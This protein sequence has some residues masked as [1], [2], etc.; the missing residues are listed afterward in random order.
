MHTDG[1]NY[2]AQQ[3]QHEMG[4]V[5]GTLVHTD[6][7]LVPIEQL[8][9][10]DMVLSKHESGKGEQA[11][12]RVINTFKSAEKLPIV[13]VEFQPA[14]KPCSKMHLFCTDNHPFWTLTQEDYES[15]WNWKPASDLEIQAAYVI[16][17]NENRLLIS[18]TTNYLFA[19][20]EMGI[21]YEIYG[22]SRGCVLDGYS[23]IIDFRNS[24]PTLITAEKGWFYS[25]NESSWHPSE[26]IYVLPDASPEKK[27][28]E[29]VMSKTEDQFVE[30]G[31]HLD[32][33]YYMDYVYDIEVEGFHTYYVGKVGILVHSP[34]S[35]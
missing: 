7:G 31:L 3:C 17:L 11:Y 12:K 15:G 22:Y 24:N 29:D 10:G 13:K 18:E 1:S 2:L 34:S 26:N 30:K 14:N 27:F 23:M 9:V 21:A 6:K 19:T 4:F 5:A 8:K 25:C 20:C 16:D 32:D 28:Y 33:T 35:Y